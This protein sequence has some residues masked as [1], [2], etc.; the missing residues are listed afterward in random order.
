MA[1]EQQPSTDEAALAE[2]TLSLAQDIFRI[3][4]SS[5]PARGVR[6]G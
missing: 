5:V 2:I 4:R 6:A 3:E 1:K